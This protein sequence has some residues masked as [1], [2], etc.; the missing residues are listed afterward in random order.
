MRKLL[1][2]AVAAALVLPTASHAQFTFGARLGFAPAMGDAAKEQSTGQAMKM[3]DGMK[4]QV[5]IQL[6]GGY[7]LTNEFSLGL[8]FSYGFGQV[9][10]ALSSDCSAAGQSCSAHDTRFG[11]QALYSF[12]QVNPQFVP[13][14]GAGIGY[15]W[16][17]W[18]ATG[19]GQPSQSFTFKGWEL[20][21]LQL[22]GDYLMSPQFSIGPYVMLSL[23]QYSDVE[24]TQ[25]GLT[26]SGSLSDLGFDKTVHTWLSF[27]VRGKFDL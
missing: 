21:N 3:S 26:V 2:L 9:G 27:G 1:M 13:W 4:S 11:V 24:A 18:E 8:Y 14:V 15:E 5:P 7:K 17:T 10:G 23:A 12:T 25:G 16:G 20:L 19:G 22:G 6:E